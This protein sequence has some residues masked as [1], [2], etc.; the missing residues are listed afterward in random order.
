MSFSKVEIEVD[1]I[2]VDEAM[3]RF[4]IGSTR[5][6]VNLA[7]RTLVVDSSSAERSEDAED[8]QDPFGLAALSPQQSRGTG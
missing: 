1:Q 4:H 6:V 2:L 7:L 3:R 5:E 8:E